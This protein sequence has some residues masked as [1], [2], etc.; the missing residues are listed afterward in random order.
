MHLRWRLAHAICF[1][2]PA[3]TVTRRG[4]GRAPLSSVG[5][6]VLG[7]LGAYD[8]PLRVKRGKTPCLGVCYNGPLLV[9]YPDGIWYHSVDDRCCAGSWMSICVR[10]SPVSEAV[11]HR[12]GN[13]TPHVPLF[14]WRVDGAVT[15]LRPRPQRWRV[16]RREGAGRGCPRQP[17]QKL[18]VPAG[19]R[20]GEVIRPA[21]CRPSASA[22]VRLSC[23]T[24]RWTAVSRT[25]PPLPTSAAPASNCGL[26]NATNLAFWREQP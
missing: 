26:T 9:V 22:A 11:F 8:N 25:T 16:S 2:V 15:L 17:E 5:Q 23:R 12:L 24:R 7:D 6:A 13:R 4:P 18:D 10:G 20:A 1:F 21:T 3:P 14:S 19:P